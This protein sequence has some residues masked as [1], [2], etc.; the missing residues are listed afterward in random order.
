MIKID[1]SATFQFSLGDVY[2]FIDIQNLKSFYVYF[3][4]GGF[5]P[6]LSMTF[7]LTEP[8]L[9]PFLSSGNILTISFGVDEPSSKIMQFELYT[10]NSDKYYEP[11]FEIT[12]KGAFYLPKFTSNV[13]YEQF[14]NSS[15]LNVIR[16][17]ANQ[18]K[19]REVRTN[20]A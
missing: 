15:S 17:I 20:I 6:L 11:G 14:S 16:N 18:Y 2:D 8:R 12:I 7:K 1:G 10:D 4:A 9:M 5:R 3:A 19:F 13:G